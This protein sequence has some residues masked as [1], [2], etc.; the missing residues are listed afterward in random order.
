M[1][2]K[3]TKTIGCPTRQHT[4]GYPFRYQNKLHC[5]KSLSRCRMLSLCRWLY[6]MLSL[7]IYTHHWA[8]SSAFTKQ[9]T[10]LGRHKWLPKSVY[11]PLI[12]FSHFV[13]YREKRNTTSWTVFLIPHA[14]RK[15]KY[16]SFFVFRFSYSIRNEKN[17]WR[18]CRFSCDR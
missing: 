2:L 7:Q 16:G 6:N 3:T 11:V 8:T 15:T 9:I 4:L 13:R 12:R 18:H 14:L 1:L 5:Q 17:E 10:E